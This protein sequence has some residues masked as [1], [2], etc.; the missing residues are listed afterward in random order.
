M[1]P[2]GDLFRLLNPSD[3]VQELIDMPGRDNKNNDKKDV[4]GDGLEFGKKNSLMEDFEKKN[5]ISISQ[6]NYIRDTHLKKIY[7]N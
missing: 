7:Q 3:I 6:L 4:V 5:K 2:A 1:K